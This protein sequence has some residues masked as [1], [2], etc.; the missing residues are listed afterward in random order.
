[1]FLYDTPIPCG[2]YR[3]SGT[4][5]HAPDFVERKYDV[6]ITVTRTRIRTEWDIGKGLQTFTLLLRAMNFDHTTTPQ[7][8]NFFR[9]Y[10]ML[11]PLPFPAGY[12]FR[13]DNERQFSGKLFGQSFNILYRWNPEEKQLFKTGIRHKGHRKLSNWREYLKMP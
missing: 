4:S 10:V 2:Q 6:H 12:G 3:G 13:R 7:L 11:G 9:V 8:A 5:H 1:M